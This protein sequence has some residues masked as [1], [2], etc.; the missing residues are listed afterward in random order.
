MG[1]APSKLFEAID[2]PL[3][4]IIIASSPDSAQL[5]ER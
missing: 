1:S 5:F 2:T 4:V 3:I